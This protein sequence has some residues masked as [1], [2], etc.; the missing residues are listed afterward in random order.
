MATMMMHHPESR[1][2]FDYRSDGY[3][4]SFSLEKLAFGI[5]ADNQHFGL[6]R[7]NRQVTQKNLILDKSHRKISH[8]CKT[9][10]RM[11]GLRLQC[12]V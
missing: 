3:F 5:F 10:A 11:T 9:L 4:C 2:R 1:E 12:N 7:R 8:L 6:H